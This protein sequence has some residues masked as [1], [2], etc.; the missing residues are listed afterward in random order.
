MKTTKAI[1]LINSL[2]PLPE[3]LDFYKYV[4]KDTALPTL[5]DNID[6]LI[7]NVDITAKDLAVAVAYGVEK[8][9]INTEYHFY[10]GVD[11][12]YTNIPRVVKGFDIHHARKWVLAQLS[13][14]SGYDL[15]DY[16]KWYKKEQGFGDE[17]LN[18][19]NADLKNRF[20]KYLLENNAVSQISDL[21]NDL[22]NTD[23]YEFKAFI[24]SSL[25]QLQSEIEIDI[26]DYLKAILNGDGN[27]CL[28][29]SSE[30]FVYCEHDDKPTEIRALTESELNE[31]ITEILLQVP[32]EG[33]IYKCE[34]CE[35]LI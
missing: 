34:D 27:K 28:D 30:Y 33:L 18:V 22:S 2:F 23:E 25:S 1:E 26:D 8:D 3:L 11:K 9:V 35:I 13:T 24:F 31:F 5:F 15:Y 16:L 7:N 10:L 20:L 29:E 32:T 14:F 17:G 19:D 4:A 21:V 12:F 6:E